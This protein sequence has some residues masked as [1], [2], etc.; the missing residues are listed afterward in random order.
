MT[1]G[2]IYPQL[3]SKN[4]WMLKSDWLTS[5]SGKMES[6]KRFDWLTS[7]SSKMECIKRLLYPMKTV[8]KRSISARFVARK[9][10][11][12]L[13]CPV[14][15]KTRSSRELDIR[16]TGITGSRITTVDTAKMVEESEISAIVNA[17]SLRKKAAPPPSPTS[18][19]ICVLTLF[20]NIPTFP[21]I[22]Q[23]F[24]L[25]IRLSQNCQKKF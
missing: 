15:I 20:Y 25:T 23:F 21:K 14:L 3:A 4:F 5:I 10:A 9:L 17:C 8:Q 22:L 11:L 1:E 16:D 12:F 18:K 2:P 6:I 24:C 7:I 19:K 13:M